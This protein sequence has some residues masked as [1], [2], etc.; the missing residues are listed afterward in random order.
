MTMNVGHGRGNGFHQLTQSSKAIASNFNNILTLLD[1]EAPDIVAFQEID[2]PSFWSGNF[3]H[4]DYLAERGGFGF[5]VRASHVD[6]PGLSYGTALLSRLALTNPVAVT[7]Y[8]PLTTVPTGFI[9]S[10]V[11]LSGRKEIEVDV[12]SIHLDFLSGTIRKKQA[13]ELRSLLQARKKPA[14]IMG[15]LNTDWFAQDSTV[16]YLVDKLGF[17]AYQP[18]NAAL[19]TFP[20]LDKRLD[21]I[22]LSADFEISSYLVGGTKLSDHNAVLAEVVLSA[23]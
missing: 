13:D 12:V 5:S 16:R 1:L 10:T 3:N 22:L 21:W 18:E 8:P 2:A 14:I 11:C 15:D 9:I 6:L 20:L 23:N 4:V 17:K 7:F 19:T